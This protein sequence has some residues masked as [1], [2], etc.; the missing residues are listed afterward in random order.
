[1]KLIKMKLIPTGTFTMGSPENDEDRYEDEI[2]HQVT[3]SKPFY[4]G[5]YPVTQEEYLKVMGNNPSQFKDGMKPV[6]KV[7]WDDAVAFCKKLTE[8]TN[9][10]YRLPTEAEW[11]YACRAG[12][13]TRFYWGDDDINDYAWYDKN[14]NRETHPVGQKKPN[15]F[16][17]Y[18]MIGNVLELCEDWYGYYKEGEV[19]DPVG[20]GT[21]QYRVLRGG[22]WGFNSRFCRSSYRYGSLPADR[23][24]YGG[25]RVVRTINDT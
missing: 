10:T 15:G 4:M 12:T 18:D 11:E 3:L 5:I 25:F 14:S 20:S 9:E 16:G 23:L 7:S 22:S 17:L 21:G 1:M 24:S 19:T 2:Q 13:S 6:E 8:I